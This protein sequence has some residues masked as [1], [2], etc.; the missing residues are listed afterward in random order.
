MSRLF[1]AVELPLNVRKQLALVGGE[2][3]ERIKK[4]KWVPEEN[5]HLT[6]QFLG[7]CSEELVPQIKDKLKEQAKKAGGFNFRL[8]SLGGFPSLK[9]TRVLWVGINKGSEQLVKLQGVVKGSLS[10]LGF[11]AENRKFH[12]HVTL[13][14][15]KTPQNLA[16]Q[17][18]R[19]DTNRFSSLEV[20][21]GE[22]ALFESRLR[23][24]GALYIP[25][26]RARL[27]GVDT[28]VRSC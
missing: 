5:I 25:L 18:S 3:G 8:G 7:N 13:A 26:A 4:V 11:E 20:A 1:V 15:L 2:L 12:P 6:L 17:V 14:R 22:V 27:S 28:N 9:R 19:V 23:P 16:E 10:S 21:V 24:S